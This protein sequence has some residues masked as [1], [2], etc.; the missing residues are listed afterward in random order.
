MRL[1]DHV[2]V[3]GYYF[4]VKDTSYALKPNG[5]GTELRI[6]MGYRVTTQFNWY[7]EPWARFLLGN[8]EEVVLD[9]YR[10][11]SEARAG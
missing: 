2:V 9:F 6:T 1:D 4:D 3:G 8:F 10:R 11:R 7:A 5:D